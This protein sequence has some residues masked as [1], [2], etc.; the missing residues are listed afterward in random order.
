[1][2]GKSAE[3]A[4]VPDRCLLLVR[5]WLRADVVINYCQSYGDCSTDLSYIL[6]GNKRGLV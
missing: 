1:M 5:R 2:A 4:A 6:F 3:T